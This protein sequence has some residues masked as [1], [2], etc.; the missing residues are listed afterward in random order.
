MARLRVVFGKNVRLL[1]E[2]AGYSQEA[3]ADH[4]GYARSYMSRVETGKAN[5]SLDAIE[6]FASGLSVS[7]DTLLREATKK[8]T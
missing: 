2:H 4:L 7:P 6:A 5:P 8:R 3:F 1:R